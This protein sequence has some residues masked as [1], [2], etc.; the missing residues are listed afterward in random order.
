MG[1]NICR[2]EKHRNVQPGGSSDSEQKL[3][4]R[5]E[6]KDTFIG[7][8]QSSN[9]GFAETTKIRVRHYLA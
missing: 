7:L 9:L 8:S 3:C 5:I 6:R 4:P 2:R 1:R